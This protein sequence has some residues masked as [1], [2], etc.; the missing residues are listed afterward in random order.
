M[1]DI[2][3]RT[4]NSFK[5]KIFIALFLLLLLSG[6]YYYN[7]IWMDAFFLSIK[8]YLKE[9]LLTVLYYLLLLF[10]VSVLLVASVTY[11]RKKFRFL[12]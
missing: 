11:L 6:L 12:S 3:F 2:S 1:P 9:V 4:P 8:L 7:L 5:L 10:V